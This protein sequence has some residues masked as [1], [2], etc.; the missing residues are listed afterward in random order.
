MGTNI[1]FGMD[2]RSR[3][4][5]RDPHQRKRTRVEAA[6]PVLA[7]RR[8]V[9]L[10]ADGPVGEY[11]NA[12][13]VSTMP[14]DRLR[15]IVERV[16][17]AARRYDSSSLAIVIRMAALRLGRGLRLEEAY[18][19]GLL[20]PK[21]AKERIVEFVSR[22]EFVRA[23]R[24]FNA[25][26]VE[27]VDDKAVFAACAQSH[28]LP[29]PRTLALVTPP[30]A[31]DVEGRPL[32]DEEEWRRWFRTSLPAAFVVKPVGGMGGRGVE[33]FERRGDEAWSGGRLLTP[34]DLRRRLCLDAAY[35][36]AIVQERIRNHAALAKLSRSDA[37]QCTRMVTVLK[38]SGEVEL[39]VAFQ[40]LIV[41]GHQIDNFA[42]AWTGNLVAAIDLGSGVLGAAW[43][44]GAL[45]AAHP[46]TGA[47]IAG[48][49]LPHW[50]DA[51][52]LVERAAQLFK[53]LRAVG[54]DVALTEDG[55]VLIEGNSE[56][57]AFGEKGLCYSEGDLAR[58]MRLF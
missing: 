1:A 52:A 51:R 24:P 42:G 46:D 33:F 14:A 41:G 25:G 55:P 44:D 40:K 43:A 20:D 5:E 48:F 4:A 19:A 7:V 26:P 36:R 11:A 15:R 9:V 28:G 6:Q 32:H 38:R 21:V 27:L 53:P 18:F 57:L 45:C 3:G 47:T 34:G 12:L 2:R 16:A 37:L 17:T 13:L 29:I 35:G 22:S 58:L 54:W 50:A 10:H 8:V 39:L 49:R 23:L 56:W 31:V 30:F